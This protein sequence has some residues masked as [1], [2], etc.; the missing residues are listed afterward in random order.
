MLFST[1]TPSTQL[2]G[3]ILLIKL[4]KLHLKF[5]QC[6]WILKYYR[7]TDNVKRY[8]GIGG[9]QFHIYA[10]TKQNMHFKDLCKDKD[11]YIFY[12]VIAYMPQHCKIQLTAHQS[13]I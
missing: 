11:N 5:K 6:K 13:I 3:I 10:K 4:V 8:K 1:V 2:H 7:I 12:V 9:E